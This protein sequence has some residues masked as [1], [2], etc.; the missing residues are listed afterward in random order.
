M[1]RPK[2]TWALAL[3]AVLLAAAP[4]PNAEAQKRK[5]K[6]AQ[7]RIDLEK[8]K[9]DL[10]S[11]EERRILSALDAIASA[12]EAGQAA[13]PYVEALLRRGTSA[14]LLVRTFKVAAGLKQTS[15]SA[16]IAPYV[17]H[18]ADYVRREAASALTKTRGPEAVRA[19][20]AGLRGNDGVVRGICA[21]G[22]GEL[23]ARE[24]MDDL[25]A[26]LERRV[27]EAA[28]SIGR[29][30]RPSECEKFTGLVGK[31]PIDVMTLGFNEILFRPPDQISEQDKIQLIGMLRELGT[32]EVG[33]FLAGVSER[34]PKD[35]SKKLKLLIDAAVRATGGKAEE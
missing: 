17:H 2:P 19:M 31:H 32:R 10:Q 35:W 6:S 21:S 13:V 5:P 30:C 27:A 11:R 12:G 26:A 34:W 29:M 8:I 33:N 15:S 7:A 23:G 28:G 3:A 16:A 9:A 4:A 1:Y 22:L 14:E 18:R 25:F 24:A 20:R